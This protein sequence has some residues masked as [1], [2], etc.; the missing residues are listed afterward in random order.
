MY[1]YFRKISLFDFSYFRILKNCFNL[2]FNY[3][4]NSF[5]EFFIFSLKFRKYDKFINQG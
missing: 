2:L 3:L 5:C 4:L 1:L